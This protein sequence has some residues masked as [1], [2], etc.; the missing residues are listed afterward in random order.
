MRNL[1][2]SCSSALERSFFQSTSFFPSIK[3]RDKIILIV[4]QM[5]TATYARIWMEGGIV[6]ILGAPQLI[7]SLHIGDWQ[8]GFVIL[9]NP[10]GTIQRLFAGENILTKKQKKILIR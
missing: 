7:L 1:S 4:T 10:G 8:A 2:H 3:N 9:D 6:K 5:G